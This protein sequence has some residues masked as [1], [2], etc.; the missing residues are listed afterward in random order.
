M[1]ERIPMKHKSK[2]FP[3]A[4]IKKITKLMI[5]N[6]T[7]TSL[8]FPYPVFANKTFPTNPLHLQNETVVV[9]PAGVKP[10]IMLYIDD[11]G[12]MRNQINNANATRMGVV[13]RALNGVLLKYE[14][15][16]NWGIETL[17]N[18]KRNNLDD[19]TWASVSGTNTDALNVNELSSWGLG[20]NSR[21]YCT[22]GIG[23]INWRNSN[24]TPPQTSNQRRNF[25]DDFTTIRR[26]IACL[27]P[28]G[29]S[30]PATGRYSDVARIMTHSDNLKNRCQK[31]Y[32]VMLSD[33]GATD[34]GSANALSNLSGP[35][36]RND[37]KTS[38]N[39]AWGVSWDD[40][41]NR[42]QNI[43]TY[44][45]GFG[46]GIDAN[47]RTYLTNGANSGGGQYFEAMDSNSLVNAFDE[48]FTQIQDENNPNPSQVYSSTAPAISANY[49]DSLAAAA[50]LNTG[51]WS[52][53]L[54]FFD[55]DS[56]GRLNTQS[57]KRASFANRKLLVSDGSTVRLYNNTMN[58]HN[59]NWFSIPAAPNNLNN[60]EWRDGL[61]KWM[62]RE[63]TDTNI[64][65]SNNRFQLDY[66]DRPTRVNPTDTDQRSMGDLLDNPI[67]PIGSM[68]NNKQKYIVTST[69]DGLVYVFESSSST[70]NPYDLKFNYAPA[71]ID[72]HSNNGSDYVGKYYKDLTKNEY[73]K[74]KDYPH[75][76]L[77]NGGMVARS[78]DKNGN[79]QQVFLV[80]SMGQGGRGA[81]AINIGGKN[82]TTGDNIAASNMSSNNWYTQVKL[83][84]TESG[85]NNHLGFTINSP[86][87]G[88]I[89]YKTNA[90]GGIKDLDQDIRYA[91]FLANGYNYSPQY[92]ATNVTYNDTPA[93]Y[94]YETLGQDVGL[95]VSA[96]APSFT[97]GELLKRIDIPAGTGG[98]STP[99]LVDANF[100]GLIDYAYAGDYGGGLYR[101]NLTSPNPNDWSATKIFQTPNDQPIT[102]A[103]GVY[104]NSATN[105]TVVVGTGSDVYQ[106]D[107]TDKSQQ[108]L[109][110]IFDNLTENNLI[111]Q[112]EL[113]E[114]VLSLPNNNSTVRMSTANDI[115]KDTHKGWFVKMHSTNG[116]R[117][118]AKP[119]IVGNSVVLTTRVYEQSVSGGQNTNQDPCIQQTQTS[120]T[121][122][123]SWILQFD[124]R[125]GG[126]IADS[127]KAVFIDF[128]LGQ[129]ARYTGANNKTYLYSGQ[130][131]NTLTSL[132]LINTAV[133]GSSVTVNGDSGGSGEDPN[134][135]LN[136]EIPKN[137]CVGKNSKIFTFDT[138]GNSSTFDVNGA[139][140]S[141]PGMKR[142]SWREIF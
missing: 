28:K 23:N 110:G 84:E 30:T 111:Q 38:G 62:A 27:D 54:L 11:S 134:L 70:T 67:I 105:Y 45:V 76:Y 65:N 97:K 136:P 37:Q 94:I 86:Q 131:Q 66:R 53:E 3:K 133:A 95:E 14:N 31:S 74:T 91:T 121:S 5:L 88:R 12:S 83:F 44:T 142:L 78:T 108:A 47:A 36:F 61:L 90:L 139:C 60:N 92:N 21:T 49:V 106:E 42:I 22:T 73:G 13:Q 138:Q 137:Y 122:A 68:T 114:Q 17:F 80:S 116:E 41:D 58:G 127:E 1:L 63:S 72:R 109:Y 51:S 18:L 69:N 79:G 19:R 29:T 100:D 101:F 119:N 43:V 113:L 120:S 6:G 2:R 24:P 32:I 50:S 123:Y 20:I 77:L 75:R 125:N 7:A 104:R 93:L 132:T 52:S 85:A 107:L 9:S 130:L 10:N 82:R 33:G 141:N 89:Q 87:I 15:Q 35:L 96:P 26:H 34:N 64:K 46:S 98:L 8:L 57:P 112:T 128:N 135:Q 40:S 55:V 99:T 124:V 59:N 102:A 129:D 56:T 39:D 81:F 140:V 16:A 4:R 25:T 117:I 115:N 126:A 103:P 118:T 71:K 48:I